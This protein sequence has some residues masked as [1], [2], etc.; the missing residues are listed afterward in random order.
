M[1]SHYVIKLENR[2]RMEQR[3]QFSDFILLLTEL[4]RK[5]KISG[6]EFR[7]NSKLWEDNPQ[8]RESLVERLKL[9]LTK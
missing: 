9:L 5:N 1:D 4:Q 6:E 7:L 8:N 3:R 2:A